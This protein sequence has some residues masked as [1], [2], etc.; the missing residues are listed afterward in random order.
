MKLNIKKTV[1]GGLAWLAVFGLSSCT[2][3]TEQAEALNAAVEVAGMFASDADAEKLD[4]LKQLGSI[5]IKVDDT[6][7]LDDGQEVGTVVFSAESDAA[8]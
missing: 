7:T 5:I 3:T 6:D 1:L 8:E 4:T 2:V